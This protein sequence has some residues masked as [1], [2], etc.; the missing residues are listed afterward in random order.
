MVASAESIQVG[1]VYCVAAHPYL[2]W[3]V[4]SV[5]AEAGAVAN[6]TLRSSADPAV[7][8]VIAAPVLR[9]PARFTRL[10]AA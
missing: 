4:V 8:R 7:E 5:A 10:T 6:I 1:E 2:R 9:N 3:T